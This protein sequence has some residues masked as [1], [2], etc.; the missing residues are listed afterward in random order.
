MRDQKAPGVGEVEFVIVR[1]HT[2]A[3]LAEG[4]SF[5]LTLLIAVILGQSADVDDFLLI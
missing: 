3:V 1:N 4:V 5:P 2:A